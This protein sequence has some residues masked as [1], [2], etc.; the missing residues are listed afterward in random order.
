MGMKDEIRKE[1]VRHGGTCAMQI[2]FKELEKSKS[3]LKEFQTVLEDISIPGTAITRWLNRKNIMIK[4]SS[5][6]RHRRGECCC[7]N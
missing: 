5:V 7:G 4:V 3:D 2:V 6:T 1:Q